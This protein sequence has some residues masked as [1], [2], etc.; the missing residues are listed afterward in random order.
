M[1]IYILRKQ[2]TT[3]GCICHQRN[4]LQ[5]RQYTAKAGYTLMRMIF[6][7]AAGSVTLT[8]TFNYMFT[9]MLRV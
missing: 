7:V 1:I 5:E 2:K 4:V 8:E 6:L 3:T 9:T